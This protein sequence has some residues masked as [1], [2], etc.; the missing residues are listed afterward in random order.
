MQTEIYQIPFGVD[1]AAVGIGAIQGA[2][3][4]GQL[5][6]RRIDMF[7]VA[8]IGVLTGFGGG[9]I[10]G[11]LLAQIPMALQNNWYIVAAT[12]G[13]LLGM[14][15]QSLFH[16]LGA[17][18]TVLDAITIGLFGALGTTAALSVSL[19]VLPAIFVGIASAVGGGMLRD[20]FLN[21]PIAVMHVGSLYAVAAGVGCTSLVIA[22]ILGM[23]V[24]AA[25]TLC[26]IVTVVIRLAAVRFKLYVP[27]QRTMT[28]MIRTIRR[29]DNSSD[30]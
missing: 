29:T 30:K 14:A 13:A 7:G 11:L 10:R 20:L 8:M 28:G 9:I 17:V 4:A 19:P 18:I 25:G 26:A 6:D 24:G 27:E 22:V 12:G 5:K 21:L 3:F 1:L 2:M 15:L 23:N 16:R